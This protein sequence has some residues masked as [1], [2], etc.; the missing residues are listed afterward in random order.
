[1]AQRRQSKNRPADLG[2]FAVGDRVIVDCEGEPFIG[3]IQ[4]IHAAPMQPTYLTVL[5]PASGKRKA[6]ALATPAE[7]ASRLS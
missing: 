2:D 1:M 3:R 4:S 6:A 7:F 5:R